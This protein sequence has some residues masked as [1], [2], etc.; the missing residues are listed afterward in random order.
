MTTSPLI[1]IPTNTSLLQESR[2]IFQ[3]PTLPFLRYFVQETTIPDVSTAAVEVATPFVSTYRHG[4]TL[5][6]APLT[7]SILIDEDLRSW[8]ETYDWMVALT[9][10]TNFAEYGRFKKS[11]ASLYHDAILTIN[12]NSNL[13]N[14][15]VVFSDCHPIS[16]SG[17]EFTSKQNATITPTAQI[18]FRYDYYKI[19]RL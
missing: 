6:Y 1:Q 19:T 16:L 5:R 10:P 9:K 7:V 15:R 4:G 13:P 2:F 12:T 18:T 14:L 11:D 17:L 3:I 8:E